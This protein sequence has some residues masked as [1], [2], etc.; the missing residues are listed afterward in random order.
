MSDKLSGMVKDVYL[1]FDADQDSLSADEVMDR[2]EQVE[3]LRVEVLPAIGVDLLVEPMVR[4]G[5]PDP[6]PSRPRSLVTATT[7]AV[8]AVLLLGSLVLVS[9]GSSTASLE[10]SGWSTMSITFRPARLQH[11]TMFWALVTA[12]VTMWILAS[13]RTPLMPR[14]SRIPSCSSMTNSWGIT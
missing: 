6:A 2:A 12:A 8:A 1:A 3:A 13:S 7:A 4:L 5:R 11:F 9:S 10:A 14:G